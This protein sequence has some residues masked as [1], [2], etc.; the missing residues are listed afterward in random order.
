MAVL[1]K[2]VSFDVQV[3]REAL[4]RAGEQRFSRFV[5]DAV[6]Q[7]LQR[8]RIQELL[9]DLEAEHGPIPEDVARSVDQ[10][11]IRASRR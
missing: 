3:A 10:E 5:N 2:S 1:K 11:W 4:E 6:A 9:E 7:H 8:L